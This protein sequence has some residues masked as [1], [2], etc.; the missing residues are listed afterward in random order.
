MSLKVKGTYTILSTQQTV[1]YT[2]NSHTICGDKMPAEEMKNSIYL[3][4]S[5]VTLL[6]QYQKMRVIAV[7][8][9]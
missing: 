5:S 3:R 6:S 2:S 7:R 4:L 9:I 8:R 1:S